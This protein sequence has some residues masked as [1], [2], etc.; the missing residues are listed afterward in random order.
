LERE[1]EMVDRFDKFTENARRTLA[2][3]Q[4]EAMDLR[5]E[6]IGTE[7]LLLGMIGEGGGIAARVL[8]DMGIRVET[9]RSELVAVKP[10]GPNEPSMNFGL[11]PNAKKLIQIAV[12]ESVKMGHHHIG[13]EHM[14]LGLLQI[15]E[16]V[17]MQL[18]TQFKPKQEEIRALAIR[19]ITDSDTV[20]LTEL[21]QLKTQVREMLRTIDTMISRQ[22]REQRAR[23]SRR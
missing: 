20:T 5:H 13:T 3:A 11:S 19:Y 22:R 21:E 8:R 17:G 12:D 6:H 18:L 10:K 2:L 9:M 4:D 7:H 1:N 15:P 14:L 16:C 23:V